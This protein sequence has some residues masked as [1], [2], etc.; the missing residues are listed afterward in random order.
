[1]IALTGALGWGVDHWLPIAVFAALPTVGLVAGPSYSSFVFALALIRLAREWQLRRGVP[2]IDPTFAGI[3]SGFVILCWASAGWSIVPHQTVVAAASETGILLVSA[4]FVSNTAL[5]ERTAE[6]T[7]RVV[8][9]ACV[10]G[11]ASASADM[12]LHEPLQSFLVS[13]PPVAA[14]TKYNRGL[15]YLV[16]IAWPA[17]AYV[18]WRRRWVPAALLALTVAFVVGLGRSEAGQAALAVGTVVLL[19]A[20]A[21]PRFVLIC[22]GGGSVLFAAALPWGLHALAEHRVTFAQYLKMSGMHRLEIWDYM[23]NRVFE[24]PLTGWGLSSSKF[25]PIR[26]EELS[27]YVFVTTKG[28]Y[29]HNQ[30]LQLWLETGVLGALAG[31][32][33]VLV[34]L[35]RV[36]RVPPRL[37]PFA[38]AG[39]ASAFTVACVNFSITTDSWWAALAASGFLFAVVSQMMM[40]EPVAAVR[41]Q[42]VS[43]HS[44]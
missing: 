30:W 12:L 18:V 3:A 26:P 29:P 27:H 42:A 39:F 35:G 21:W 41:A 9:I 37:Y 44:V 23:T 22:L 17:L 32:I 24:R 1:M 25:V 20:F 38:C 33:L 13:R 11:A 34:V 28:I 16:L 5:G 36:R 19:A 10:L 6:M 4:V 7:L 8:V 43:T 2:P 40:R 31:V 14:T 15:D